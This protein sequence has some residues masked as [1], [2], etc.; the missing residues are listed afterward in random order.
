MFFKIT[1]PRIRQ[2]AVAGVALSLLFLGCERDEVQQP[3][4]PTLTPQEA[5]NIFFKNYQRKE[6]DFRDEVVSNLLAMNDSTGIIFDLVQK[7]GQPRWEV[8]KT[9]SNKSENLL[10]VPIKAYGKDSISAVFA[11]IDSVDHTYLKI[12]ESQSP[13][14]LVSDFVLLYQGMLYSSDSKGCRFAKPQ[15]EESKEYLRIVTCWDVYTS[16]D[17]GVTQN[18]S[19]S[20]CKTSIVHISTPGNEIGGG[21]YS[22]SGGG[23]TGGGGGSGSG[24]GTDTGT[25]T[26]NTQT[27]C[28]RGM[29]IQELDN[30]KT[31]RE[32]IKNRSHCASNKILGATEKILYEIKPC[33]ATGTFAE[34][35]LVRGTIQF[36]NASEINEARL[37]EETMHAYQSLFYQGLD[38]YGPGKAGYTNMEFEAKLMQAIYCIESGIEYEAILNQYFK[39]QDWTDFRNWVFYFLENGANSTFFEKYNYFIKIFNDKDPNYRG[40]I[41][42]SFPKMS[43]INFL[44][45]G[46]PKL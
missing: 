2:L 20:W 6:D 18:F 45:D 38:K 32:T 12:F 22:D 17:G 1:P 29:T 44:L 31:T 28:S 5:M 40:Y 15:E 13:D 10:F 21:G 26:T 11:F 16:T 3:S 35:T 43:V 34:Y 25:E 8:E 41:S 4:S 27:D 23:N 33:M 39:G 24:T 36:R 14:T 19:Y 46:C 7:Y 42:D 37:Y 30:I 9:T